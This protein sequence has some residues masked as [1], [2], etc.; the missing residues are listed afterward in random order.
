MYKN[1]KNSLQI[2]FKI[3]QKPRQL[4]EKSRMANIFQF[5]TKYK[6]SK[7]KLGSTGWFKR[8]SVTKKKNRN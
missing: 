2:N 1:N 4:Q 8:I 6:E 7:I 5:Y 3:K